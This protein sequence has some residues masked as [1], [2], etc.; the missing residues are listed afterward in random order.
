M[1]QLQVCPIVDLLLNFFEKLSCPM[2]V[3]S[4]GVEDVEIL[5][6]Y[7]I[8]IIKV[9]KLSFG[10]NNKIIVNETIKTSTISVQR[11][12]NKVI[13]SSKEHFLFVCLWTVNISPRIILEGMILSVFVIVFLGCV[14]LR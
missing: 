10:G 14:L 11:L 8:S 9:H 7:F 1:L 6:I 2:T 13:S 5:S 12:R 4:F 3:I